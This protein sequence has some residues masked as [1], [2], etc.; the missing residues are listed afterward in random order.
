MFL[1]IATV[2]LVLCGSTSAFAQNYGYGGSNSFRGYGSSSGTVRVDPYTT[3]NG[4]YVQGHVR[5]APDGNPYNNWS[6]QGNVNP[7]TGKAGTTPYG[8]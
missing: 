8:W 2:A 3:S 1:R 4:T 5:S 7:Y 6:A